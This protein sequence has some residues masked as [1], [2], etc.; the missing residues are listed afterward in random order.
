MHQLDLDTQL[1]PTAAAAYDTRISSRWSINGT[2]NGGYLLALLA[3]AIEHHYP[4]AQPLILTAGYLARCRFEPAQVRIER[5]S[6]SQN[7]E[8]LEMRLVQQ[9]EI[10]IMA[11]AT[12]ATT[13]EDRA[14]A[15]SIH[16]SGP[17]DIAPIEKCIAIPPFNE[18]YNLYQQMDVRLPSDSIGWVADQLS[19]RSEIKG[20]IRFHSRR[21][22]DAMGVF[23]MADAFPPPVMASQGRVA[24]VPTLELSVCLHNLPQSEWLKGV[25]RTRHITGGILEEDG[26]LWDETDTLV[27]VCRQVA[28]FRKK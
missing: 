24:W 10:K 25:F 27:A 12:L 21:D 9:D 1:T 3:R 15:Q 16:E 8:R 13:V 14:K 22:I 4:S 11:L 17:P 6:G 5:V 18:G 2:P 20:W 7:F 19:D 23:L 28:Q 26:E